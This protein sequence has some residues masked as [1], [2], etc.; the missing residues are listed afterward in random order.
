MT[1]YGNGDTIGYRYNR[2]GLVD[3]TVRTDGDNVRTFNWAYS[4][5]G[6]LLSHTDSVNNRKYNYDYDSLGRLIRQEIRTQDN[7]SHIGF[8]EQGYDL[9]N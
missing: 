8:V 4:S 7:S 9:R 5:V 2:L 3:Q 6:V 1:T